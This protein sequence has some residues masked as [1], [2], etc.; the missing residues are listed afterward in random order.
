MPDGLHEIWPSARR[1]EGARLALPAAH[2]LMVLSG[3]A[4]LAWQMVWTAEFGAAMGHEIVAVLAVLAAFFGGL[5]LGAQA[6][7]RTLARSRWP[8]R[9]YAGCEV[10]LLA[11][12]LVLTVAMPSLI[13]ATA[14]LTDLAGGA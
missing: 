9:W 11:W 13:Q 3:A 2:L 10:L 14:L 6:L 7:G 8:G 1:A 4:A 12:G 5:A